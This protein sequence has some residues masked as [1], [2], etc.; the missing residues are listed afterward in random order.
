MKIL[1][2][3]LRGASLNAFFLTTILLLFASP[4]SQARTAD[5]IKYSTSGQAFTADTG[6]S[7]LGATSTQIQDALGLISS[8]VI[9][10]DT[11][12]SDSLGFEVFS[13]A[14]TLFPTQGTDYF[15]M[16][17]GATA[18]AL[19][20]N[21]SPST[22]TILSG[23]DNSQNNDMVQ[24]VLVLQPPTT[25]SCLAFDFAYYSEEFP[26]FVGSEFNDAFIAE[27]GQSTFQITEIT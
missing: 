25:A 23:L 20:T 14:A 10:I 6:V 1:N 13:T 22:S 16:S 26:E 3:I 7:I 17:S 15:V 2:E 11:G 19:T 21:T 24:T 8:D 4:P 18:D 5:N 12:T 27:I 9:S